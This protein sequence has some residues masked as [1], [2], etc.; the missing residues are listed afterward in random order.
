MPF[1]DT[2]T[3]VRVTPEKEAILKERLG[4]AIEVF[5]GKSEYWLMLSV[6]DECRMWFRGYNNFPIAMVEVKLF[7][8]ADNEACSAMTAAVCTIFREELGIKPEHVYVNYS[9]HN[10]WGWNNENF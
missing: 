4:R 8:A 2:K 5:P 9:F 6:T 7:G 1:I 10:E 3:N